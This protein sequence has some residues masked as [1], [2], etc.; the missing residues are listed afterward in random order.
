VD[1]H[2]VGRGFEERAA[3]WLEARGMADSARNVRFH[4]K[5]VDLVIARD[6]LVA[7]VEVKG[8]Q[9]D[10]YGLPAEAVTWKK[11]E[12]DRERRALVGRASRVFRSAVPLRRR[13]AAR[14]RAGAV[15]IHHL[16]DAWRPR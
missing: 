2:R 10:R 1:T 3:R 15:T 8:R 11:A 6:D 7:F 4:R 16:E 5:E 12:R 9:S 13:L 14:G